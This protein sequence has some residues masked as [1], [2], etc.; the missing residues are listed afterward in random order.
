MP[1][2]LVFLGPPGSGKGTQAERL[3]RDHGF[4]QLS[5]GNVLR[6]E[7]KLRSEVGEQA[8]AFVNAGE[9]VPDDVI[10]R[11]MLAA[12]DKLGAKAALVLDGFPRTLPQAAALGDGLRERDMTLSA[13][14][15]FEIRDEKIVARISGRRV[16][17]DCGSTYNLEFLPPKQDG[18]CDSCGGTRLEQRKDDHPTVVQH[19]LNEYHAQT[20]P[21]IKYYRE[22]GLL[23]PLDAS[24][25]ADEV[26]QE[27]LSLLAK[28]DSA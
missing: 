4:I 12:V 13:V 18:V 27:I 16:C 17:A 24:A 10:T 5:S 23:Q 28:L 3:Q 8:A 14:V 9:L 25:P 20:E 2:R 1:T 19:R 6:A 22:Q 26:E 7:I 11:V 15:D 21:L